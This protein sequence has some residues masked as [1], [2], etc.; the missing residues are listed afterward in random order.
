[1]L[2][3]PV[4][5]PMGMKRREFLL[6]GAGVSAGAGS[7][8]VG[9]ELFL[10]DYVADVV[11]PNP[12]SQST[13]STFDLEGISEVDVFVIA[14]Q[15]NAVG[16][17]DKT[18]S[19]TPQDNTAGMYQLKPPEAPFQPLT[20][21]VGIEP[22]WAKNGSAWPAFAD[23]Y[24]DD[25]S[26]VSVY[27]P[28]AIGG[29]GVHPKARGRGTWGGP[30][31]LLFRALGH[32]RGASVNLNSAGID[33]Q[34]QGILWHQGESDAQAIDAGN[35]A[36]EEYRT[37]FEDMITRYRSELEDSKAPF[38]IFQVGRPLDEDTDGFQKV[39]EI[40][41]DIAENDPHTEMI[42]DD[43]V[44][45]AEDEMMNDRLHY[46]QTALN[47][48]GQVGAENVVGFIE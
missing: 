38:H 27:V 14:G 44:R 48:M 11:G 40:Q 4:T 28:T 2:I 20:D 46:N 22:Y 17:G 18:Q 31:G 32:L 43:C 26:R 30:A 34:Y 16:R 8:I 33:Y 7:G 41:R 1:M 23:T 15:S 39:R 42:F 47:E 13:T 10:R 9:Y 29:T 19:P 3:W 25:T 37:A 36:P 35:L 24:W 5:E 12:P 21:S 45:F 6:T